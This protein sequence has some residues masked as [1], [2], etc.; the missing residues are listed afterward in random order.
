M[1]PKAKIENFYLMMLKLEERMKERF[2]FYTNV[3]SRI[4]KKEKT[5]C[6]AGYGSEVSLILNPLW[7]HSMEFHITLFIKDDD[8]EEFRISSSY[9]NNAPREA[10]AI[11]GA[12][13]Y[14]KS[15]NAMIHSIKLEDG[16]I[17]SKYEP[18]LVCRYKE[19]NAASIYAFIH[20]LF[21]EINNLGIFYHYNIDY[22]S[23]LTDIVLETC[24][25]NKLRDGVR[26]FNTL[27]QKTAFFF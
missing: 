16:I 3:Y 9:I 14:I 21:K 10:R 2:S 11:S 4:E 23:D 20:S 22:H 1:S 15:L 24:K 13:I 7:Y 25:D 26:A 27:L 19:E 5:I 17:K 8:K 18:T 12:F 6:Y